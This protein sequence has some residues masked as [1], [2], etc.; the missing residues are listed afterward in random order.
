MLGRHWTFTDDRLIL[1][2]GHELGT[3]GTSLRSCSCWSRQ[4]TEINNEIVNLR[5]DSV[6]SRV[7]TSLSLQLLVH[8]TCFRI[9]VSSRCSVINASLQM[10]SRGVL[11]IIYDLRL[12]SEGL[13]CTW[14]ERTGCVPFSVHFV[15]VSSCTLTSS[16]WLAGSLWFW[17]NSSLRWKM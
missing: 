9:K 8:L 16:R 12:W 6:R 15:S 3:S 11:V 10:L 1:G 14:H 7:S 2:K 5:C 13:F 17:M 4:I